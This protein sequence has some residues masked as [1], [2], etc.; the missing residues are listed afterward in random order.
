MHNIE[1]NNSF[2]LLVLFGN[3]YTTSIF[4][5]KKNYSEGVLVSRLLLIWLTN[6]KTKFD[7]MWSEMQCK[8]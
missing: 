5:I 7:T 6:K 1:I 3:G 2:R 8:M 4:E